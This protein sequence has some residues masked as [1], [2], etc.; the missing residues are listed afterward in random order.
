MN[1]VDAIARTVLPGSGMIQRFLALYR[2]PFLELTPVAEHI[3]SR[4]AGSYYLYH[5]FNFMIGGISTASSKKI[6]GSI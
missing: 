2:I 4:L 5:G 1:L 6:L 3:F